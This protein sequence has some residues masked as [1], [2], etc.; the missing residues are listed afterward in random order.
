MEHISLNNEISRGLEV[1]DCRLEESDVAE[2]MNENIEQL[3]ISG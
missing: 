3:S 2:I 1:M